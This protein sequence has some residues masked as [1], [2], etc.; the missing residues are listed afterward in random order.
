MLERQNNAFGIS[1]ILPCAVATTTTCGVPSEHMLIVLASPPQSKPKNLFIRISLG[2]HQIEQDE[3]VRLPGPGWVNF[4]KRDFQFVSG[5]RG[6]QDGMKIF[7]I[8][9]QPRL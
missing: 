3:P 5:R 4:N 2:H 1:I 7:S 8:N 9:V 6:V